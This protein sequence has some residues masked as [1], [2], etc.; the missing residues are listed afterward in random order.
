VAARKLLEKQ[1]KWDIPFLMHTPPH[2]PM[3]ANLWY[4][5]CQNIFSKKAAKF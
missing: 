4:R 3:G 2:P 1:A 5:A